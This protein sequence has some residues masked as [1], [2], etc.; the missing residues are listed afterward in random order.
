MWMVLGRKE[1]LGV[2]WVLQ[3]ASHLGALLLSISYPHIAIVPSKQKL[4]Q[5]NK[6]L[7]GTIQQAIKWALEHN[8]NVVYVL[9]DCFNAIMRIG[10]MI[11]CHYHDTFLIHNLR[12]EIAKLSFCARLPSE[13]T[14]LPSML[15]LFLFHTRT[16]VVDMLCISWRCLF[17]LFFSTGL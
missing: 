1:A 2:A 13:P 14:F 17:I 3:Q 10:G 16:L 11:E 7:N 15:L 5:S 4:K 8:Y 9:S 12:E 6:L